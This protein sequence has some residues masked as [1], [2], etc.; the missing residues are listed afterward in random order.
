MVSEKRVVSHQQLSKPRLGGINDDKGVR[1][2]LNILGRSGKRSNKALHLQ[3]TEGNCTST[4]R[5]VPSKRN[6][7]AFLT[8]MLSLR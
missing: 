6:P 2:R 5:A 3:A 7:Q 8:P 1:Q 4:A